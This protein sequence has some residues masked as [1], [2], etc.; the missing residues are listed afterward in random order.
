[1][2]V[3]LGVGDTGALINSV[4]VA[5]HAVGWLSVD[6][7]VVS[8]LVIDGVMVGLVVGSWSGVGD[9]DS[10]GDEVKGDGKEDGDR[11]G[12]RDGEFI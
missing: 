1:M 2:V 10:E 8:S 4:T 12:G 9:D 3:I 11:D 7:V 5:V 6:I